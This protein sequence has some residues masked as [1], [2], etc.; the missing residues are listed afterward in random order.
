MEQLRIGV[1]GTGGRSTIVE[2]WHNPTGNS[3]VV[4][5]ADVSVEALEK[6]KKEINEEAF[7]TTD[8]RELL[9][10]EDIDAVAIL[11]PDY[12]HEEH[13]IAALQAGKHVYC[14]K[15]L[16]ITPEACDRILDEA[17][18]SGKHFMIGFNMR[19]MSM[20]QTMKEI[21]DSGVIGDIKAVWVRH[22]VGLGGYFYYHD[23]HGTAANTTSLLLQK[24]SHDIDVIH[25]LTGSYAT[26]VSAFGSLDY[27]G[28]DK[29][30]DLHC[31]DCE[32]K[33]TC[34]DA[35]LERLTQC[36]FREEIDVEDNNM[37]IM[38]LEGGIKASYM[39]CHFTPDYSRN[40]TIIGTK[41]RI[42]NDDVNDKVYVKTRKSGSWQSG[43]DITYEM[44]KMPGTHGGA[45]P[46]ICEDFVNL[47]LYN[48]QPLTSPFAGR[49]SVAVGCAATDSIRAGGKVVPIEQ[50]RHKQS[51]EKDIVCL[52]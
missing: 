9:S 14:E 35:S 15:P 2:Y 33:D 51:M 12:L 25:W 21:I 42:E 20:Y 30:N 4:G 47:V 37:L 11:T 43:S 36:A 1:I 45:D 6:F 26:K 16:A 24:A 19:Y 49:M 10:R 7:V 32:L 48:K 39:Q 40:Y 38:E 34:P 18:R 23:W 3:I 27:Y 29:P 28:G 17:K 44:K 31:P 8:Y 52:P 5:A 13:A 22:F 46:R 41:G 50:G